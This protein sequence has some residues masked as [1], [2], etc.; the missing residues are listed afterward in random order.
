MS[1][2]S[3]TVAALCRRRFFESDSLAPIVDFHDRELSSRLDTARVESRTT[4]GDI[5]FINNIGDLGDYQL[6]GL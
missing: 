6:D 4:E 5:G 1:P 2:L 3:T